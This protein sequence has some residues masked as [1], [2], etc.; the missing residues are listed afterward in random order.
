MYRIGTDF[1]AV[2]NGQ[3]YVDA[4]SCWWSAS[5]EEGWSSAAPA[6]ANV[7]LREGVDGQTASNLLTSGRPIILGGTVRAPD[8][9]RLQAAIDQVEALLAGDVRQDWLYVA[10]PHV[11]RRALVRRDQGTPQVAKMSPFTATWLL[12]LVADDPLRFGTDLVTST[13]LPSVTGGLTIPFTIPF[14]I[15]STVVSGSCS[16]FNP[17]RITGPVRLRIDGPCA[18]P[19]VTHVGS[20]L[21]L[22]FAS[23]LVINAGEWLT[24]DMRAQTVLLN[25]LSSRAGYL[26]SAGFSGFEP[27]LN[28]W[29]FTNAIY[30]PAALLTVTA[31]P[32]WP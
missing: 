21:A 9:M 15:S 23:S 8:Q 1:K 2:N 24:V 30:D 32:A 6:R 28:E 4:A 29:A 26:T 10:E 31:A 18:G 25:D 3:P 27:G 5:R 13:R 12:Q 17:G 22:V 7:V 19:I 14:T 16:L 11:T 20:G